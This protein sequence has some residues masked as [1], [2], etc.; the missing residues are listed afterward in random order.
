M[1]VKMVECYNKTK[2]VYPPDFKAVAPEK[3]SKHGPGSD[4]ILT[5]QGPK[6]LEDEVVSFIK[7]RRQAG[8]KERIFVKID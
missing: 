2:T 7:R 1:A 3:K 6:H 4:S 5:L 8:Y